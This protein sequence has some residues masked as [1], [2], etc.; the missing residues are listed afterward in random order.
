MNYQL[1]SLST[2]LKR[3]SYWIYQGKKVLVTDYLLTIKKKY[4][5][6]AKIGPYNDIWKEIDLIGSAKEQDIRSADRATTL[7]SILL[8]EALKQ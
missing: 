6:K 1:A 8:Q 3:V 2:D 4:K 7:G 5:I